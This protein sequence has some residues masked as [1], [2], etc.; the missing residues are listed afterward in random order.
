MLTYPECLTP[1]DVDSR[2]GHK[3]VS[4]SSYISQDPADF[5][6]RQ[7]EDRGQ[8]PPQVPPQAPVPTHASA[9][10][11]CPMWQKVLK[12]ME[13]DGIALQVLQAELK[14]TSSLRLQV[15]QASRCRCCRQ[16]LRTLVA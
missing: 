10:R 11:T 16:S 1:T 15:L 14:D 13:R 8:A 9:T 12:E 7:G 5:A 3:L 6:H 2:W 4:R